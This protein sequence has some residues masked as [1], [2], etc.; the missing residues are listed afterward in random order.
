MFK[1]IRPDVLGMFHEHIH[2][3]SRAD[4]AESA[5]QGCELTVST[6]TIAQLSRLCT[7]F[8]RW[9]ITNHELGRMWKVVACCKAIPQRLLG[10]TRRN[11]GKKIELGVAGLRWASNGIPFQ[12]QAG[13]LPTQSQRWKTFR[14]RV[15]FRVTYGGGDRRS[16]NSLRS[17][18]NF[19]RTKDT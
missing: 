17:G 19:F 1:K 2:T 18:C 3:D 15:C 11:Y 12:F 5:S 10:R 14:G 13:M 6:S 4:D 9:V 8:N 7:S 16:R